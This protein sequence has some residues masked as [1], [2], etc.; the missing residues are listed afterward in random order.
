M[1]IVEWASTV[2][3]SLRKMGDLH[4]DPFWKLDSGRGNR[5]SSMK[6]IGSSPGLS[7]GAR[8]R[9]GEANS[10][11]KRISVNEAGKK[12]EDTYHMPPGCPALV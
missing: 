5:A 7:A 2:P 9:G 1:C 4:S 6:L 12:A 8:L 10:C 3:F 11:S